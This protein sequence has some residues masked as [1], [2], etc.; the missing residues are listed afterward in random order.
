MEMILRCR[1]RYRNVEDYTCVFL[2]KE[3]VDGVMT[4]LNILHMKARQKPHSVY[5]QFV[6]PT[7]G[8]EAIYVH[9]QNGGKAWVHDVGIGRL[10]AGTISLDPRS[11]RAMDGNRHP[12]NE[13]GIGFLIETVI[14]GWEAEMRDGETKVTITPGILVD[15]RPCTLIVSH[16]PTYN[17]AYQFH[18]VRVYI[19]HEHGLPVRFEAYDWPRRPGTKGELLEEYT[20]T[21]LRLNSGLTDHDFSPSNQAYSFGRF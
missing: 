11:G 7:K 13:A 5:F 3:R 6:Q 16:H 21:K 4:P 2:K 14:K 17:R 15:K 20:Y 19:D 18:E 10:L 1:E 8:R 12:I 9:G